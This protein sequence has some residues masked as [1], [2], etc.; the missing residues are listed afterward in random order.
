LGR[1][2]GRGGARGGVASAAGGS[3]AIHS[4]LVELVRPA[5]TTRALGP[6]ASPRW[7]PA[8]EGGKLND[9][10]APTRCAL[11]PLNVY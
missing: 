5:W 10:C 2:A 1:V 6:A 8:T 7:A 11:L 9:R 4:L 3:G